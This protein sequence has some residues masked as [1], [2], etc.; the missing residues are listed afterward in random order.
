MVTC[1]GNPG[2]SCWPQCW[3][4]YKSTPWFSLLKFVLNFSNYSQVYMVRQTAEY[5]TWLVEVTVWHNKHDNS[6]H[7]MLNVTFINLL[8]CSTCWRWQSWRTARIDLWTRRLC[9][10]G[11]STITRS[12]SSRWRLAD[13]S[14]FL[15]AFLYLQRVHQKCIQRLADDSSSLMALLYL[16]RMHQKCTQ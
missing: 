2:V 12:S 11:S 13:D 14:S 3:P 1:I 10:C 6:Q 7:T 8:G 15:A 9:W 4:A 16:Q 5:G